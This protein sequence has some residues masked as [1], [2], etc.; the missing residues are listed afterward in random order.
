MTLSS[1]IVFIK[2]HYIIFS[3]IVVIILGLAIGLPLGLLLNKSSS[4]SSSGHIKTGILGWYNT[5]NNTIEDIITP[6]VSP[7]AEYADF[8]LTYAWGYDPNNTNVYIRNINR[9][10]PE[11]ND[12]IKS[13]KPVN[14]NNRDYGVN[15]VKNNNTG[16]IM[17]KY[18]Q[19]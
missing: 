5:T 8:N 2:K 7:V 16:K 4:G 11:T 13:L 19:F 3:I 9:I 6:S 15:F 18:E 14:A 1:T 17:Y 12:M 10:S